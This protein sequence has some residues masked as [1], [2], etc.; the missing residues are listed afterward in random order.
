LNQSDAV[1]RVS[2]HISPKA[3]FIT[4]DDGIL[5]RPI[6]G[7]GCAHFVAHQLKVVGG[8]KGSTACLLGYPLAVRRLINS[9]LPIDSIQ[10]L[11]RNDVWFNEAVPNGSTDGKMTIA[12]E[13]SS[14][15]MERSRAIGIPTREVFPRI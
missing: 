13:R 14:H 2:K 9:F 7:T 8:I 12:E 11:R 10:G 3:C 6:S 1:A 15:E 5:W 4:T